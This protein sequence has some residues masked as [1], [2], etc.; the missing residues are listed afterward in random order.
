[1][2]RKIIFILFALVFA[3]LKP[4]GFAEA[5]SIWPL[6][7]ELTAAPGESVTGS[8]LLTNNS[9]ATTNYLPT[10]RDFSASTDES[11]TPIFASADTVLPNALS[12]WIDTSEETIAL[13]PGESREVHF[14]IHVPEIAQPGG[15][16]T[17]LLFAENT[18]VGQVS[19]NSQIGA[20]VFLTVTGEAQVQG[21]LIA[22]DAPKKIVF[23]L[24]EHFSTRIANSGQT[25]LKPSGSIVIENML[26]Q[27]S[28]NLNFNTQSARVL[29]NSTRHFETIWQKVELPSGTSELVAEWKNFGFGPYRATLALNLEPNEQVINAQTTFWVI[30]WQLIA[31]SIGLILIIILLAKRRHQQK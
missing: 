25:T 14:T 23:H 22:F 20:L 1:M 3:V 26:G 17:A 10:K 21:S 27:E 30:P 6:S 8:V 28:A 16:Y 9:T 7:L 15:Y 2:R 19:V 12:A 29:Q 18:T 4:S 13:V 11:G 5:T 31:L 24:P